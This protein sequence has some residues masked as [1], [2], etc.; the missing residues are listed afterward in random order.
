MAPPGGRGLQLRANFEIHNYGPMY[1][2]D[3]NAH[4]P[5]RG[6]QRQDV[7]ADD[8][9]VVRTSAAAAVKDI[10]EREAVNVAGG[11]PYMMSPKI[12]DFLTLSQVSTFIGILAMHATVPFKMLALRFRLAGD[13]HVLVNAHLNIFFFAIF[14]DSD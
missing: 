14:C 2:F 6:Y 9:D 12:L 8:P 4:D 11:H 3:V 1:Q 5:E 10:S 13:H 7:L